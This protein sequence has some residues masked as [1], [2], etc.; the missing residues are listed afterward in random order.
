MVS[1]TKMFFV[2][3][4][5]FF[6]TNQVLCHLIPTPLDFEDEA[7]E[8]SREKRTIN[9]N[10][11]TELFENLSEIL[12]GEMHVDYKFFHFCQIESQLALPPFCTK[13]SLLPLG[14]SIQIK[15]S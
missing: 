6:A 15:L 12:K 10:S 9:M 3:L 11:T 4:I 2:C 7:D 1:S 14:F 8:L 5:V 13:F